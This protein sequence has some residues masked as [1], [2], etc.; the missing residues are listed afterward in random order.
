M[1]PIQY[2]AI[3]TGL[4]QS[5]DGYMLSL[6]VHPD[7]LPDDLM[8]DFI[9]SRYMVV[10]VRIGD[11]DKPINREQFKK[12][13]PAVAMAGML[14]RDRNFWEYVESVTNDTIMTEGEC[15]EWMKYYFEIDSRAELKTNEKA[16]DA[17]M[18]FKERY[19]Q[20]KK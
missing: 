3:K 2:E 1:E 6:V 13:H 8:K 11:D 7:D 19:D 20:W 18:K 16:R 5:K 15:S 14:C 10:M 12:H 9:G 17:F 4:K